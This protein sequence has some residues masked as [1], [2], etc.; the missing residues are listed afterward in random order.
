M[1]TRKHFQRLADAIRLIPDPQV[2]HQVAVQ[3]ARVCLESNPR[4]DP[5]KFAEA[6]NVQAS[7]EFVDKVNEGLPR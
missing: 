3:V 4:F 7:P 2:R 6:A 5:R 1:L